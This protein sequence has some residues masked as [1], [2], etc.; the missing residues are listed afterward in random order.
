MRAYLKT[1]DPIRVIAAAW[2]IAAWIF[3]W[4]VVIGYIDRKL[5]EPTT[6]QTEKFRREMRGLGY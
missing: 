6:Q 4:V 3:F 1:L 2:V 5:N